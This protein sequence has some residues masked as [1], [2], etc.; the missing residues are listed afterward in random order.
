MSKLLM[1]SIYRDNEYKKKEV[2]VLVLE[3]IKSRYDISIINT[4][5]PDMK[6]NSGEGKFVQIT[7]HDGPI[8]VFYVHFAL[9]ECFENIDSSIAPIIVSQAHH[10]G[11]A[12]LPPGKITKSDAEASL[13]KVKELNIKT[14]NN[15][16][17]TIKEI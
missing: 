5:A 16:I 11:K 6:E 14:G 2:K 3:N 13:K 15:L 4:T 8:D 1:Y 17:F 12:I 10:H 7:L 9:I